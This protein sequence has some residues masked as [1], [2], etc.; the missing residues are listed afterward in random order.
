M[1]KSEIFEFILC[2]VSTRQRRPYWRFQRGFQFSV[3]PGA[4]HTVLE[5]GVCPERRPEL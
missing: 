4:L 5:Q 3:L 1:T 2:R